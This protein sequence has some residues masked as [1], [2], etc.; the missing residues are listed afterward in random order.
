M[1]KPSNI[2]AL[3]IDIEDN[4]VYADEGLVSLVPVGFIISDGMLLDGKLVHSSLAT[5]DADD[6]PQYILVDGTRDFSDN[7]STTATVPTLDS[8]LARKDYVDG[9]VASGTAG[10]SSINSL[11]GII[12]ISGVGETSVFEVGQVITV[13]T[14]A[15]PIPNA[16]VGT[17]G[18]TVISGSPTD[19]IQGFRAE[20]VA[21]SGSLQSQITDNT[22]LI[23]TTSGHLQSE[24]D[25]ISGGDV[26]D[27]LIGADGITI[28]SGTSTTTVSAFYTEFVAAS[29]T[30]STEIDTDITAH[31][32][33]EDA[34]HTRYTKDENDAIIGG[35]NVTVVSGVNTITINSTGGGGGGEDV[36]NALVGSDGITV[37][38][39]VSEDTISGFYTEFVNASGVLAT[40][41]DLQDAYNNGNGIIVPDGSG[42]KPVVISGGFFGPGMIVLDQLLVGT[43][44]ENYQYQAFIMQPKLKVTDIWGFLNPLISTEFF[45]NAL[46]PVEGAN[47]HGIVQN[48]SRGSETSPSPVQEGDMLGSFYFNGMKLDAGQYRFDHGAAILAEAESSFDLD[49][50]SGL[51]GRLRFQTTISGGAV[52]TEAMRID[53]QHRV[54]INKTNPQELLHVGG[55]T[56]VS[57]T[58]T[59]ESLVPSGIVA[60]DNTGKLFITEITEGGGGEV[61]DALV[62]VDGV[63]VI[64][65]TGVTTV[66]GFRDE[67]VS[68]SGSLQT[69]I[70]G[71]SGGGVSS[72]TVTGT[73]LT[74]GITMSST[75]GATVHT[76]GQTVLVSGISAV[77]D[78]PSPELADDLETNGFDVTGMGMFYAG[79]GTEIVPAYSFA[80]DTNVGMYNPSENRLGLVAGSKTTILLTNSTATIHD[81]VVFNFPRKTQAEISGFFIGNLQDGST[82]YNTTTNTLSLRDSSEGWRDV[83]LTYNE[84]AS[85]TWTFLDDVDIQGNLTVG[86]D[87]VVLETE[88]VSASGFLQT[89][90]DNIP[91]GDVSDALVGVDGI[92]IISGTSTTTVS[93][94]RDEFV[95]ASGSLQSQIG[96]G[97]NTYNV[98]TISTDTSLTTSERVVLCNAVSGTIVVTLPT[99]A[100]NEGVNYWIKKIDSTANLVTTSGLNSET[101]DG[102][103][104]FD[105]TSKDESITVVT[106]ASN[107]YII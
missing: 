18:I 36:P 88:F 26:S 21:A 49:V 10:V 72:I 69:Q 40:S 95:A 48:I 15:P 77:V 87:N 79:S 99:A 78:D 67:F 1:T 17:G 71:L 92:T 13:S 53:N 106:D 45:A 14:P 39:G 98:T 59:V 3:Y 107:W 63:T 61:S 31:T 86:G 16:L 84:T 91:P 102:D 30:L 19:T 52:P 27:A 93:G 20:F 83:A 81:D 68:S 85:G 23:V 62:G 37:I 34:H 55:N 104:T 5:L 51:S 25:S 65:G 96:G 44:D 56:I 38:S 100:G 66:S 101:I 22:T 8:H 33:I 73:Q 2:V 89:Q 76:S 46:N 94:F 7:I 80:V 103:L 64:S 24:I 42:N 105:L 90:I 60:A 43:T 58:L 9:V 74:G 41:T 6:H 28:T 54:G 70:D 82:A 29:G 35:T 57:G 4:T 50:G 11:Q 12:T 47:I 32:A 75:G 97:G